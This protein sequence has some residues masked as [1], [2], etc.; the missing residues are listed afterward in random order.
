MV[1]IVSRYFAPLG[2]YFL[3]VSYLFEEY[4]QAYHTY[5]I[6]ATLEQMMMMVVHGVECNLQVNWLDNEIP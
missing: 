5:K 2:V 3:L 6:M 1:F 4:G